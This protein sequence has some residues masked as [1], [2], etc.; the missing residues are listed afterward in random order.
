MDPPP[1]QTMLSALEELYALSALDDEG[2]LTRLG[3]NLANFP[4]EPPLAKVLVSSVEIGCAEEILT[5]VA[6]LSNPSVFYRP[7]DKQTQADQK[8]AKFHQPEG[9]H[10]TLLTVYNAWRSND[11][12]RSWC[13]ENFIQPRGMQ[14]A[15]DVRKQLV[16]IMDRYKHPIISAGRNYNAVRRALCAGFFRNTARKDPQE[17]YKTLIEGTPVYIHPSSALYGKPTEWVL[18]H[19]VVMTQREYMREVTAI[20]SKWLL[21]A[22]PTFFKA[23]GPEKLSKHKKSQK[24]EP[25]YNKFEEKDDWR[26][27]KQAKNK[28]RVT[29]NTFG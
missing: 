26:I 27:S 21:E 15:Q 5:I 11:Y 19:E 14:R 1:T 24:I 22:A 25:L 8:K 28:A 4:M 16:Q 2:L 17:G 29:S 23:V 18:Y 20:E 10:L 3:R 13:F 7:K 9:D 12:S 6:M